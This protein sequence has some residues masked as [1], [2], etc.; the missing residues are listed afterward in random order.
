MQLVL[1]IIGQVFGV[2]AIILGFLSY[3]MKTQKQ[4]LICQTATS[5]VFCIHYFLIGATTGMAM[6]MVNVVRNIFITA[7][8]KKGIRVYFFP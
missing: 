3:Q 7:E 8:I 6:N 2:I 5:L 1:F 4:L